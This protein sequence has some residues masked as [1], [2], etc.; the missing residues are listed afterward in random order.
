MNLKFH[1]IGVAC[2]EIKE[3]T[4]FIEKAFNIINKSEIIYL[5]LKYL[6]K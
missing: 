4:A 1:H 2:K 5:L 6:R 3:V